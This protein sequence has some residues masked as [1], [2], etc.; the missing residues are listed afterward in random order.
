M[1]LNDKLFSK[2]EE[3]IYQKLAKKHN[4][5]TDYVGLIA[6]G[7]RKAIRGKGLAIKNELIAIVEAKENAAQSDK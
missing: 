3:T 7:D 1:E 6:R 4:V 5:S 2:K